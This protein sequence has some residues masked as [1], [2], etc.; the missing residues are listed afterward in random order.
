MPARAGAANWGFEMLNELNVFVRAVELGSISAAAR[1]LRLSAAAASHRLLQLEDQVGARL[2]NRTTRNLQP[3]EAGHIFYEHALDVLR[4]V[5]RAESSMATA[6]GV[7]TGVLKVTA[8]L[9]FGRRVLAPLV[10]EFNEK[11][12]KVEVRLRLSDHQVDLLAEG[13]DIAVRM[14]VLTDSSFVARK[15]VDCPRIVCASPRYIEKFG[16]P[17]APEDLVEHNCLA[18]RFPGSAESR[19]S[20][21]SNEGVKA[22]SV[23]GR[24]D[25]DDGDVLTQWAL[26]G[27]GIVL[28]P[29]WEV[30]SH[31]RN[32]EL[33]PLL[34]GYEAE[35]VSLSLLYPH[36]Q[37]LP[38]KVRVFADYL[39][40][41]IKPLIE[42]PV[43]VAPWGHS[44]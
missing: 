30:A 26:Q 14:A 10:A 29:Y 15:L 39:I 37:Q 4:A 33:E 35:P 7:P 28:K 1:S 24:F 9:G 12:P 3:T 42:Q 6:S 40:G 19:W 32:G 31:L 5:E 23:S 16:A 38:V 20:F 13:I 18:L 27:A 43:H 41:C 17:Q 22:V 2:L 11:Y 25:A 34:H 21:R 44:A 8:P 36:R